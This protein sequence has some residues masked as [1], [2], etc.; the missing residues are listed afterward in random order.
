MNLMSDGKIRNAAV[1]LFCKG[2]KKQFIQ[3][4]LKLARFKGVTK[5]E[6]IDN[7]AVSGNLFDLYEHAMQFLQNYLPI[8]GK[9]EEGNPFRTDTLAIPFKKV[10]LNSAQIAEKLKDSPTL[11]TLQIDLTQLEKLGLVKR[12]GKARSMLWGLIK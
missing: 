5:S 4:Q 8:S 11:R 2:E 3:S 10:L 9:I 12:E 1:I 6:F 7:K